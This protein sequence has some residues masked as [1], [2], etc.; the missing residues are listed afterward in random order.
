MPGMNGA[1]VARRAQARY[2]GLPVVFVS[3]YFDTMALD[4][5]PD[6]IVLRKPFDVEGLN[7]AVSS[8]LH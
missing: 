5:I 6:A 1:E 4:G 8:V 3:G 2:P 7:K